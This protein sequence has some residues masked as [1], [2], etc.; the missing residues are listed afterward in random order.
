[1]APKDSHR[2]T[3]SRLTPSHRAQR[4]CDLFPANFWRATAAPPTRPATCPRRPAQ[5][6][7]PSAPPPGR[8]RLDF[9]RFRAPAPP[10]GVPR[11]QTREPLGRVRLWSS[12]CPPLPESA[13]FPPSQE[14]ATAGRCRGAGSRQSA[15]GT[16]RGPRPPWSRRRTAE[17]GSTAA[18]RSPAW[19]SCCAA[20]A[21]KRGPGEGGRRAGPRSAPRTACFSA[22]AR[23][24]PA[25][26]PASCPL[27]RPSRRF[28]RSCKLRAAERGAWLTRARLRSRARAPDWVGLRRLVLARSEAACAGLRGHGPGPLKFGAAAVFCWAGLD[29]VFVPSFAMGWCCGS[30]FRVR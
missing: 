29:V 21:G 23:G 30:L 6:R 13:R 28:S 8:A 7:A 14:S 1:M 25:W 18:P 15:P 3:Q 24:P 27:P 9:Q 11:A 16:S 12:Q 22:R 19:S 17:P 26:R 10:P 5:R 20:R 2:G 4:G